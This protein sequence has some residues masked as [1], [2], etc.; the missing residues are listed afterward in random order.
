MFIRSTQNHMAQNLSDY[1]SKATS[2][3]PKVQCTKWWLLAMLIQH[4]EG[5][6]IYEKCE[7]KWKPQKWRCLFNSSAKRTWT[8]LD[9]K[10]LNLSSE[11]KGEFCCPKLLQSIQVFCF[12]QPL[13]TKGVFVHKIN[14]KSFWKF[15]YRVRDNN[16]SQHT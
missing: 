14:S 3:I 1:P 12:V 5:L 4:N 9:N 11:F 2:V 7:N 16:K 8:Y 6:L 15:I 13:L 10:V